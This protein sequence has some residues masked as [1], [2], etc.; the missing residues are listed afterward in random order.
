MWARLER[1]A[2]ETLYLKALAALVEEQTARGEY[3]AAIAYARCYLETDDLAE[4]MHRR[5]I[6]LYAATGD[7]GAALRQFERCT[8]IL[9]REL[10]I[11]P[12]PETR[13]AYRAALEGRRTR[14]QSPL[15]G[16]TWTTLPSLDTPLVGREEALGR[17]QRAYADA[18][19]GHG[20]VI[21]ISGEAGIGKSRLMQEFAASLAGQPLVLTGA[22]YP[23]APMAPYQP[24]VQ[25]LRSLLSHGDA[26]GGGREDIRL[27]SPLPRSISPV[28]LAEAARL[29]P[30]L[31]ALYPDLPPPLMGEPQEAQARLFEALSQIVLGLAASPLLLCLEDLHWADGATLDWLGYLGQKLH[32]QPLLIIGAY[33]SEE[34]DAMVALRYNLARLGVLSELKLTGLDVA[35]VQLLLRHLTL[36]P[37]AQGGKGEVTLVTRFQ[38]ATGGN[39][40]F[41]LETLKA[42]LET[43]RLLASPPDAEDLPLPDT[44]REAVEARLRRLSP[45][46]RQI[47]EA[48]A[49]LGLTFDLDRVR[50]TAGRQELE[51]MDGLDEL[52]ARQLLSEETTTYRFLHELTQ[53]AVEASLSPMRRRLLHR[54]AGRAL[55]QLA[56]DQTAAI[57]HHFEA[58]GE[59]KLALHYHHLAEQQAETMFAWQ[60]AATHQ[61]RVLALL[62]QIDPDRSDRDCLAQRGHVLVARAHL[63]FLQGRLAERDAD[64]SALAALAEA[65]DDDRLRLLLAAQQVRYLNLDGWYAQAI[66]TAGEGLILA[67]RLHD[68]TMQARLLGQIGFAHYFLGQPR[69]ALVA[70]ESALTT[71]SARTDPEMRGRITHILGYVYFHLGDFARS[72]AYQQEAY[73]CHQAVGDHNRVAWDGLD[74]GTLHLKMGDS[75]AARRW[76]DESLALARRIGARPAEAYGLTQAGWW[77]LHQGDYVAAAGCFQQALS[78]QQEIHSEHSQAAQ[79]EGMG[80]A[81]YHLGDLAEAR[82]WLSRAVERARSIGHRRR[83]AEA[84]IGLGLVEIADHRAPAAHRCLTE[85]IEA[86]RASECR[87]SLAA[88]LAALARAE[89]Q[90]GDLAAAW[91]HAREAVRVAQESAP[92]PAC[93]MWGEMEAGLALLAQ[94]AWTALDHTRRAMELASQAQAA[95]IGPE[96]AHLAHAS[97]LQALGRLDEAAEQAGL[98]RA[99]L[100]AKAERI[101]DPDQ[102]QRYLQLAPSLPR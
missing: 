83:L 50:L 11:N 49:V 70:L 12:L 100:A 56:P 14:P 64:L 48:G 18:R 7:R 63:R 5:L 97:V 86:A 93:E 29:L 85:A 52:V 88:G 58:S 78:I 99:I 40:F 25:A 34:A 41:L 36:T 22:C 67:D 60:E 16:P 6:E 69:P 23:G 57:A 79:E 8:A 53:R 32:N 92:L 82:R 43:G 44:V 37:R 89:R 26:E 21:L 3:A 27:T 13:A 90:M 15:A 80:W 61:D 1:R 73:A 39:P 71:A 31:R 84:L 33:R 62:D 46:A 72:L 68:A 35:S 65:A 94:N 51:A 102:R 24:I 66:A 38:E 91:D 55:E 45:K 96:Q 95:W 2:Q 4:D 101:P 17:L 98:A 19:S 20:G 81:S 42:L 75:A 28:W 54:R 10:G 59:A 74:I 47:L 76:L 30:E 87:E 9:E 77:E